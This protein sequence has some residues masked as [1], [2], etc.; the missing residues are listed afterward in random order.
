MITLTHE[1]MHINIMRIGITQDIIMLQQNGHDGIDLED[2]EEEYTPN[3]KLF[4]DGDDPYLQEKRI[5]L[6][7]II[8]KIGPKAFWKYI[9]HQL[10][11]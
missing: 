11:T 2:V 10:E 6:N 4:R 3:P 5:E 1:K 9:V 8:Q 7:S